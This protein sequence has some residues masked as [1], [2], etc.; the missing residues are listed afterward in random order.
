M[1]EFL[2]VVYGFIGGAAVVG[3]WWGWINHRAKV[4][5]MVQTVENVAKKL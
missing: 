1:N 5:A 3:A 2:P 4:R